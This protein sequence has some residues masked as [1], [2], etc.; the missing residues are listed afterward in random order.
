VKIVEPEY[1][2]AFV[3]LKLFDGSGWRGGNRLPDF[4]REACEGED[5]AGRIVAA[6]RVAVLAGDDVLVA[7]IIQIEG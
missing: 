7:S 2:A 6:V 5:I 1:S 4:A 3:V